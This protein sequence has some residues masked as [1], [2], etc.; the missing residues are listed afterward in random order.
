MLM[1]SGTQLSRAPRRLSLALVYSL[2]GALTAC[3]GRDLTAPAERSPQ[4]RAD[5]VPSGDYPGLPVPNESWSSFFAPPSN[6]SPSEVSALTPVEVGTIPDST[7]VVIN[8]SGDV[9]QAWNPDCAYAPPN[10]PCQSGSVVGAFEPVPSEGGSVQM[11]ANSSPVKLRGVGGSNS[12]SAIGLH[13]P[14]TGGPLTGKVSAQAKYAWNPN[15]GTG[16]FS[17]YLSGGYSVS[18]MGVPSPIGIT[19]SGPMDSL[20]TR[21]YS[22]EPLYGLQYINPLDWSWTWPAGAIR[23]YFIPGDSVSERAGFTGQFIEVGQCQFQATCEYTP[24]GPGRMQATA[25]VETRYAMLRSSNVCEVPADPDG[26]EDEELVSTPTNCGPM[27]RRCPRILGKVVTAGI[28]VAGTLHTFK[29][30]GPFIRIG[31]Q[32]V[33]GT[34]PIKPT[35]SEDGWWIAESGTIT[36]DCWGFYIPIN[37]R[38]NVFIGRATYRTGDL[39]MVMGPSHPDF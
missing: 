32:S 3:D 5:L 15:T 8:V 16:P 4:S 11:W 19:D 22:V 29:F 27:S 10:W 35:V 9:Q 20:G 30:E 2:L 24:T 17:Y 18:A 7:W 39:H 33:P 38:A 13:Y 1:P 37:S 25:Y 36:V 31:L 28:R 34:Y 6:S 21:Q 14:T 26:I 23:W 12:T